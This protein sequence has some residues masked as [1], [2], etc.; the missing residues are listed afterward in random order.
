MYHS[1][2]LKRKKQYTVLFQILHIAVYCSSNTLKIIHEVFWDVCVYLYLRGVQLCMGVV[3]VDDMHVCVPICLCVG[4]LLLAFRLSC[5]IHLFALAT[6]YHHATFY[7]WPC[8]T[9]WSYMQCSLPGNS[10]LLISTLLGHSP[11]FFPKPVPIFSCI[12]CG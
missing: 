8:H 5:A 2:C 4:V 9:L 11:A 3:C 7:V 1:I 6:L 10:S 12:G